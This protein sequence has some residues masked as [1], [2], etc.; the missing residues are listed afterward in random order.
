MWTKKSLFHQELI[1]D[2][3]K[4]KTYFVVLEDILHIIT[5]EA[6]LRVLR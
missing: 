5:E 3:E 1:L 2:P 4:V 6:A